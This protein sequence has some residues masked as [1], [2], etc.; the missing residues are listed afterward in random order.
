MTG[1]GDH[2]LPTVCYVAGMTKFLNANWIRIFDYP[3]FAMM[4]RDQIRESAAWLAADPGDTIEH[5]AKAHFR[6]EDIVAKLLEDAAIIRD[7]CT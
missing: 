3:K 6:K 1:A 7:R 5:I 2:G 4:L